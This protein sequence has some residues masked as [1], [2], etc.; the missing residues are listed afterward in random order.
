MVLLQ[1]LAFGHDI[2]KLGRILKFYG[3]LVMRRWGRY[4][5]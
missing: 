4:E 1:T 2:A 5:R 3:W